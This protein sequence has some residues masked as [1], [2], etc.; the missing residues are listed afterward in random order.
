[1]GGKKEVDRDNEPPPDLARGG[2]ITSSSLNRMAIDAAPGIPE[3]WRFDGELLRVYRLGAGGEY[4]ECDRSLAFPFLPLEEVLRVLRESD[5][6]DETSLVR[7]FRR[8][9]VSS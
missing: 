5:T 7:S 6:Q 1:M 3:V 4:G 8:G 2:D 9:S